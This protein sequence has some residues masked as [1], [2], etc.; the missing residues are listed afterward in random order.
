MRYLRQV[1]WFNYAFPVLYI[2]ELSTVFLNIRF[3]YRR[4]RRERERERE[5]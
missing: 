4:P 3:C 2:G 5:K 1:L